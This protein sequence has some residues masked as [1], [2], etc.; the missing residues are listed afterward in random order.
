MNI[1]KKLFFKSTPNEENLPEEKGSLGK[2][3][4]FFVLIVLFL[5]S[6]GWN[7]YTFY[8]RK[9]MQAY[10]GGYAQ[11]IQNTLTQIQQLAKTQGGIVVGDMTLLLKQ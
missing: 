6:L 10:Q 2:K 8:Q 5:A 11:G 9:I 1:F 7:L 3:I 4:F